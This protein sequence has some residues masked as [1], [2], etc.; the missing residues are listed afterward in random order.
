M[1]W[2]R[3]SWRVV[4][5]ALAV[6]ICLLLVTAIAVLLSR[7]GRQA[8]LARMELEFAA[9]G[10]A[11]RAK[12][13]RYQIFSPRIIIDAP[14]FRTAA[15]GAVL[16]AARLD[17]D[18]HGRAVELS[19]ISPKLSV[20]IDDLPPLPKGQASR[21]SFTIEKI[22]LVDGSISVRDKARA[23]SVDLE[24]WE[25]SASR[26]SNGA[27]R[28]NFATGQAGRLKY[29][30]RTE[31][32]N[33][34]RF[35]YD[36]KEIE[37]LATSAGSLRASGTVQPRLDVTGQ[38]ETTL[39]KAKILANFKATGTLDKPL[40]AG[41]VAATEFFWRNQG[42]MQ[43]SARFAL[44][45]AMDRVQVTA[46][47]ATWRGAAISGS[48]DLAAKG[49]SQADLRISA[50]DVR[51]VE[52]L[53]GT[54]IPVATRVSGNVSANWPGLDGFSQAVGRASVQFS[55]YPGTVEV[56]ADGRNVRATTGGLGVGAISGKG[57]VS[58][59]RTS[60][61]LSGT[62]A[63]ET[64]DAG[65]AIGSG[66]PLRGPAT[67]EATIAGTATKPEAEFVLASTGLRVQESPEMKV[68]A[69]GHATL[70]AVRVDSMEAVAGKTRVVASGQADILSNDATLR[71]DGVLEQTP[72]AA[73]T[74]LAEGNAS[75]NFSI[76]GTARRPEASAQVTVDSLRAYGEALGDARATVNYSA[77]GL[78]IPRLELIKG[79]GAITG[80]DK[81]VEIKNY[82][83][84]S[85]KLADGQIFSGLLNGK[86]SFEGA[87]IEKGTGTLAL[88]IA[89]LSAAGRKPGR[90]EIAATLGEGVVK[91]SAT[92]AD[93]GIVSNMQASVKAPYS[94]T[95]EA[96]LRDFAL[97]NLGAGVG[98][99]ASGSVRASGDLAT[100]NTLRAEAEFSGLKI[101]RGGEE[102]SNSGPVRVRYAAGLIDIE[103]ATFTSGDSRVAING[104]VPIDKGEAAL[105]VDADLD[106]A[107]AARLAAIDPALEPAGRLRAK[108]TIA[109]T[110]SNWKPDLTAELTGA[111]VNV[112]GINAPLTAI[113]ASLAAGPRGIKLTDA[114]A[115]WLG[116]SIRVSG[117][118]P[119]TA[120]E[121]TMRAE[122][123]GLRL[124]QLMNSPQLTGTTDLH[125]EVSGKG[126]GVRGVTAKIE[127][128]GLRLQMGELDFTASSTPTV[129]LRDG[130]VRI[131]DFELKGSGTRFQVRGSAA[132]VEPYPL[133]ARISGDLDAAL[134]GLF[135]D[136]VAAQ[137]RANV[138]VAV[139]GTTQNPRLGGTVE[140][141]GVQATIPKAGAVIENLNA[142]AEL[143]GQQITL[144]DATGTLNGGALTGGGTAELKNGELARVAVALQSKNSAWNIPEGL[145]TAADLDLKLEGN[146]QQLTLSGDINILEG[147]YR[148]RLVIER[149]LLNALQPT[150]TSA[151][152]TANA[153]GQIPIALNVR[154][155][156]ASPILVSNDLLNGALTADLRFRGTP[157][158]PGLTGRVDLE[159]GGVLY[160]G[161]RNYLAERASATFTNER[162]IEPVLDVQAK[163]RAG[164]REI[165]L[166]LK[167]AMGNKLETRFTSDDGLPE[168][169]VLALLVTG[170]TLRETRGAEIDIAGDQAL[171]YLTG[172]IGSTVSMQASRALGVKL[173]RIDPSLIAQEAE[174]TA[175]LTLGQDITDRVGLVYSV[176][177]R[178]ST[179]Q[180]WIGSVQVTPRFSARVVR[181][182][183]NTYRMQFQH[184]VEFGG[185]EPVKRKRGGGELSR[186]GQVTVTGNSPIPEAELRKR[187]GLRSGKPYD[188][189]RFRKGI[190][191][192]KESL[193][194]KGYPEA[195]VRAERKSPSKGVVD[196]A[197]TIEAAAPVQ[198]VF[199]GA[200]VPRKVRR[201]VENAWAGNSFDSLRSKQS[202]A[203]LRK[204]FAE[205]GYYEAS[206]DPAVKQSSGGGKRVVFEIATGLRRRRLD[207]AFPGA[208]A[209][210]AGGLRE[211]FPDKKARLEAV[212]RPEQARE[213]MA[214][215][216]RGKG[217]L[218]ASVK[219]GGFDQSAAAGTQ[220][221]AFPVVEGARY[222][223]GKVEVAGAAGESAAPLIAGS[224][225][226]PAEVDRVAERIAESL[227]SKGHTT[228]EAVVEVK[229]DPGAKTVDVLYRVTPGDKQ[230]LQA[231]EVEGNRL[232][233]DGLVRSQVGLAPGEPITSQKLSQARRNLYDTGAFAF[234]DLELQPGERGADGGVSTKLVARVREV[235]PY[236]LRY[237]GLYDTENG[238]GGIADF[239][240]R[241]VLGA[242][243]VTG[244]RGR[245]DGKL[246]EARAYFEQPN[247]L[248]FPM[249]WVT[250]GFVRREINEG[251]LTDRTGGST[252]AEFRW[253][254]IYRLNAGYRLEQVHTFEKEPDPIFPFDIR[255]RV[256]P[257]T[258]G[259]QRDTRNDILDT[260]TG[261]FFSQIA[262]FAPEKLGSQLRYVKYF[263]QYFHYRPLL[264]ERRFTNAPSRPGLVFAGSARFGIAAGLGGQELIPSER[265]FSG[266]GTSVRGF[267]QDTLGAAPG[268]TAVGG[269]GLW[270]ANAEARIPW[271]KYAD[272]VGFFDAGNVYRRWDDLSLSGA[273]FSAGMGIRIRTPY[274]LLRVDYGIKLNRRPGESF[275]R[276][277]GGL[278]QAF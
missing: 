141:K 182:S 9:Q 83:V 277:F 228:A 232:T 201:K 191:R 87:S 101:K 151:A 240:V 139:T 174:P 90:V 218:E 16:T 63:L 251:F 136:E 266:G 226:A 4:T 7:P 261:S 33:G 173:V 92:A 217:Y 84:D 164:G 93:W 28:V 249:K 45:E 38:L 202:Q 188:F 1:R 223:V 157:Q 115:S 99:S 71:F 171:S 225:Y 209:D 233:S 160:L 55:A 236:E 18:F 47:Q 242:A 183:D 270:I 210:N 144:T 79:T 76:R 103:S 244:F 152:A 86:A 41:D 186:V 66:A 82:S 49:R 148:E 142:R 250:T 237:G 97:E 154:V 69:R 246:R 204:H 67:L 85:L 75:G 241:N 32:I 104:R 147:S 231:V 267:A 260:R 275:G 163:T 51:Q 259:F 153:T 176:N 81:H 15:N 196:L 247:L 42:P 129:T 113:Q 80:D 189:F 130:L 91:G 59:N 17:V 46:L 30:D 197:L 271:F 184:D 276:L 3:V 199:E 265:F 13:I 56:T 211:L 119:L 185:D 12:D 88:S 137:G 205:G 98:G 6:A 78:A 159:E 34:L 107:L 254:R 179:D 121:Y 22:R 215:Y 272:I 11:F 135:T 156:T 168:P 187:F 262:E 100:P 170:R 239:S 60:Q 138:E 162:K 126:F 106:V 27:Y 194:R 40:V 256:A 43:G 112:P 274:V 57:S 222:R 198:F 26:L 110:A 65:A 122:G 37:K 149:G 212:L 52:A 269:E 192:V 140:L 253:R 169:D 70:E 54:K 146:R 214:A 108:G 155:H 29:Q 123:A 258:A 208:S 165:S 117:E 167:G 116:G 50:L 166:E 221:F 128:P 77:A 216:Y 23:I 14:E 264:G 120:T 68:S 158:R 238:P 268:Q 35:A 95:M 143:L 2:P 245:Y 118:A 243:R 61:A 220:R 20:S 219:P 193:T 190:D 21:S 124:D 89:N 175:R 273:R 200:R 36:G 39:E 102:A 105:T 8:A 109:G 133:A 134:V 207:F 64:K 62:V 230:L 235:R 96:T 5:A 203:L 195:S 224:L 178:N 257:L 150:A 53:F 248:R 213:Q 114:T 19:V 73:F 172:S 74:N 181:Q 127:A 252:T 24:R 111:R 31:T 44:N 48:G 227:E 10:I 94:S 161:G 72:L 131:Q 58:V 125:A 234:T 278:G 25:A 206:I 180:I 255:I 263:G 177:L 132:L 145:E 229:P